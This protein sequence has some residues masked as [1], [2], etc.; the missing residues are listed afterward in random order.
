MCHLTLTAKLVDFGRNEFKQ[1][2]EQTAGIDFSFMTK[3]DQLPV[4]A[5]S[6]RAP[7]IFIQQTTTINSKGGVLSKEFEQLGDDSL[8]QGCDCEGVVHPR[9]R[10]AH[11]HF[12][13]VKKRMEPNVPP[14]LLWIVDATGFDQE[15]AVILIFRERFECVRN[16]GA[17]KTLK[18]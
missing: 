15:L 9:L 10:I 8:E 1:F 6:R 17:R 18:H 5:V 12:E 16:A 7:A 3:V 13:R 11:P 14:N 4:D 2:V